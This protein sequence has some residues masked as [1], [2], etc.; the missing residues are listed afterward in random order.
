[1]DNLIALLSFKIYLTLI[2]IAIL[3][4]LP[5]SFTADHGNLIG[6]SLLRH[7]QLE[8]LGYRVVAIPHHLWNSLALSSF[9]A[10]CNY[11]KHKLYRQRSA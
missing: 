2:R 3:A 11:L 5:S 9:Q 6:L 8:I 10:K 4:L 7:R 1:M